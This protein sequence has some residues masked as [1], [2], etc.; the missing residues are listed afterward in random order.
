MTEVV[1]ML[2]EEVGCEVRGGEGWQHSDTA[3]AA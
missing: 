3:A 2:V 1:E